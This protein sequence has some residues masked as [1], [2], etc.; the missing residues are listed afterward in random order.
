[1][2]NPTLFWLLFL[3]GWTNHSTAQSD[4]LSTTPPLQDQ[5][6]GILNHSET[7]FFYTTKR[8]PKKMQA[9]IKEVSKQ[10]AHEYDGVYKMAN[11]KQKF[12]HGCIIEKG[13]LTRRLLT[14]RLV[15]VANLGN[16]H[17]LCYERGGRA[18]NLLISFSEING[19]ET[20]YYNLH[21]DGIL[22]CS[23]Y[24]NLEQIKLA[25]KEARFSVNYNNG[26]QTARSYVPF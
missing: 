5:I 15:F 7:K 24:H 23:E 22:P 20:S 2:N 3:F 14:R 4:S 6:L 17:V 1:M 21:L 9:K 10:A 16:R 25:L 8:I 11:P 12:R 18:H 13:L 19:Q 26:N